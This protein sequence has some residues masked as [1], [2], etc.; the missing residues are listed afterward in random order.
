[1]KPETKLRKMMEALGLADKLEEHVEVKK[2]L[3]RPVAVD[4][5]KI[6]SFRAMQGVSYFLQ[7]PELFTLKVCKHCGGEFLVS[8]EFVACCSYTCI[9]NDLAEI[10]INWTKDEDIEAL[11]KTVYEGNEPIWV[12]NIES[13]TRALTA[14]TSHRENSEPSKI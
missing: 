9:K 3:N 13:L 11:V 5:S 7:A 10:G 14:L 8:R 4:E 12:R 1:M 6:Q 2:N